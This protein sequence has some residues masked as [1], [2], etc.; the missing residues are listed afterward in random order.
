MIK[1]KLLFLLLLVQNIVSSQNYSI[2]YEKERKPNIVNGQLD[3][4]K[5]PELIKRLKAQ[6]VKVSQY[7]LLHTGINSM[8]SAVENS[9]AKTDESF[10]LTGLNTNANVNV[11]RMGSATDDA[12]LYK[13]F[14]N[15][16]FLKTENIIGKDFLIKDTLPDYDWNISDETKTIGEFI[17]KKALTLHNDKTIVAW[18]APSVPLQNGPDEYHGLPGLIIELEDGNT[19]YRALNI[20]E[21]TK[22]TLTK[23]TKGKEITSDDY[24]KLKVER[25]EDL[26]QQFKN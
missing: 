16:L 4:I 3:K 17:C 18:Y 9:K 15:K 1:V 2:T 7:E 11:I 19:T 6:L 25:I 13:D 8:F 21:T 20:K 10:E 12:V 23:P 24:Q 14:E 22:L 26:K 5:D